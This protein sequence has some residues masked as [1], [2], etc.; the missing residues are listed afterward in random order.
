MK[1][2]IACAVLIASASAS[3]AVIDYDARSTIED[4]R[5]GAETQNA[6]TT[7]YVSGNGSID[8]SLT[9]DGG[10]TSGTTAILPV[11]VDTESTTTTTNYTPAG[12]GQL[13]V[14]KTGGTNE[15]W[16]ACGTTVNDWVLITD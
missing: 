7:L 13:L 1:K 12:V 3:F 4:I 15:A 8:G 2:L 6:I 14:G 11:V 5:N 10:I 9:V 16:I